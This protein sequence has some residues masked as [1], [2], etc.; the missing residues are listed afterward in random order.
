[1]QVVAVAKARAVALID[2]DE[3]NL[4]GTVR[5]SDIVAPLVD[6]FHFEKFPTSKEEFDPDKGVRFESGKFG[7]LTISLLN[8]FPGLITLESLSNTDD[9]RNILEHILEWAAKNVGLTYSSGMIKRW[10]YISQLIFY[11]DYPLLQMMSP[12]LNKL[13]KK[14]TDVVDGLFGEGLVYEVSKIIVGHDPL[15]RQGSIAGVSIEHR[16]NTLF[17][18]NKFFSEAPLPT[19]AHISFLQELEQDLVK[20]QNEGR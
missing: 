11:S 8:I 16:A 3:L 15:K 17:S 4:R 2:I 5:F 13:A 19:D 10:G 14:T 12:S 6:T 1:M 20:S 9:S 18:A 7:E